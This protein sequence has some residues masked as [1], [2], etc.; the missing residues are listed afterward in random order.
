MY[1]ENSKQMRNNDI[2]QWL[3][4]GRLKW[5]KSLNR[6]FSKADM[7]IVNK[8]M[9]RCPTP[10]MTRDAQSWVQ[11]SLI[12][13]I[14]MATLS[15]KT[16]QNNVLVSYGNPGTMATADELYK[17]VHPVIRLQIDLPTSS[18]CAPV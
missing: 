1:V 7:Q 10:L 3:K 5:A 14:R 4:E 8:H 11:Y 18:S 16:K 12:A 15:N 6:H 9:K 2:Q 17:M 13:I